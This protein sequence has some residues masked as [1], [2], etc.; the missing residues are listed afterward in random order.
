MLSLL[1]HGLATRPSKISK[2]H[3][4]HSI[5]LTVEELEERCV[6]SADTT[7]A[8]PDSPFS[9]TAPGDVMVA[10][11]P[12]RNPGIVFLGDSITWGLASGMGA[13][14]WSS[15]MAPHGAADYGVSG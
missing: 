12:K 11:Q 13:P 6:L 7:V 14:V 3:D 5:P 1:W 15:V 4:R 8:A 10:M 9:F 2:E